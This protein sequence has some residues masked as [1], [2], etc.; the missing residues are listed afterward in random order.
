MGRK[1][2]AA[3][4]G[5]A[6]LLLAVAVASPAQADTRNASC[7]TTGSKGSAT[8]T[9][10]SAYHRDIDYS[11]NDTAADGHHAA[12]RIFSQNSTTSKITYYAWHADYNGSGTSITGSTTLDSSAGTINSVGVQVATREGSTILHSCTDWV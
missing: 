2:T 3:G 10:N 1:F 9:N 6:A 12:I 11:V 4:T 8:F 5:V 7:S